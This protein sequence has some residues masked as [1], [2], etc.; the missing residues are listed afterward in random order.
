M[1]PKA[2]VREGQCALGPSPRAGV[3]DSPVCGREFPPAGPP[4][5]EHVRVRFRV[6]GA[7]G[8]CGQGAPGGA[9]SAPPRSAVACVCTFTHRGPGF[10]WDTR[11][12]RQ[13]ASPGGFLLPLPGTSRTRHTARGPAADGVSVPFCVCFRGLRGVGQGVGKCFCVAP[14]S[15]PS[16]SFGRW[17]VA[18]KFRG[19]FA[20]GSVPTSLSRLDAGGFPAG[21][22]SASEMRQLAS[23][24]PRR[25]WRDDM[26][27]DRVLDGKQNVFAGKEEDLGVRVASSAH[28]RLP[29][30]ARPLGQ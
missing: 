16:S 11:P 18:C 5:P 17:P 25:M 7:A 9:S 22:T 3:G 23:R 8:G 10:G 28:C 12:G 26:Q 6:G 19:S 13:T 4:P 24:S 1:E 21:V 30:A 29:G 27:N 20:A 15:F 2:P 14:V